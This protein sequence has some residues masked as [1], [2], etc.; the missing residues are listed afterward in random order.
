MELMKNTK[1]K[2]QFSGLGLVIFLMGVIT[3]GPFIYFL[4]SWALGNVPLVSGGPVN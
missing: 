1:P 2:N 4:I 3:F